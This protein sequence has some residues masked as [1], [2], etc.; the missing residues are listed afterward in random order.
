MTPTNKCSALAISGVMTLGLLIASPVFA[1]TT[2]TKPTAAPTTS[3]QATTAQKQRTE[4]GPDCDFSVAPSRLSPD[5]QNIKQGL[6]A[7]K[8]R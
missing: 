2:T 4:G 7:A 3:A 5:C 1:Q 8:V 6:D